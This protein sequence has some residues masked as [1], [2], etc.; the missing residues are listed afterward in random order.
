MHR[1][2]RAVHLAEIGVV[3][4]PGSQAATHKRVSPT[5]CAVGLGDTCS[6]CLLD[7]SPWGKLSRTTLCAAGRQHGPAQHEHRSNSGGVLRCLQSK[8]SAGE[9]L[10]FMARSLLLPTMTVLHIRA[11]GSNEQ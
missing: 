1:T 4:M 8:P 10:D 6:V 5:W 11:E 3:Q 7:Q 9:A 2:L